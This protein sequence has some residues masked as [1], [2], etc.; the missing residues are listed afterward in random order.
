[1]AARHDN[2][3]LQRLANLVI[4]RRST[5]KLHKVDV[6]RAAGIEVNTYSKVEEGKPVRSTTYT[7][8]EPILGWAGG[9]CLDIL[10]GA[11]DATLTE[12]TSGPAVISPIRAEDLASDVG[13]A[14]QDAAVAVSDSMTAAEIRELKRRVVD[15]LLERWG[16]RGA[17]RG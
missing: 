9:S 5:L 7:K 11:T 14:V 4:R 6:A 2:A 10:S 3:A 8:I 12:G 1:M 13:N 17:D 16:Q 15:E